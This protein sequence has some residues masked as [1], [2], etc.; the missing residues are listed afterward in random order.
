[1][2]SSPSSRSARSINHRHLID[3]ILVVVQYV[4]WVIDL[5][6]LIWF[7]TYEIIPRASCN[8]L[9]R[10][11]VG[12][13]S[14]SLRSFC[15]RNWTAIRFRRRIFLWFEISQW[16]RKVTIAV[17]QLFARRSVWHRTPV[18]FLRSALKSFELFHHYSYKWL[19]WRH[20][21]FSNVLRLNL[22]AGFK[23]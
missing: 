20:N 18:N 10:F 23:L 22:S 19:S 1:M 8:D 7:T 17:I 9:L 6:G 3:V 12:A 2:L 5:I 13:F 21:T 11:T 14:Y 16:E 15:T 4:R